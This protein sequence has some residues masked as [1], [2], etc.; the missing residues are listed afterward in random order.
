MPAPLKLTPERPHKPA[1]RRQ[2]EVVHFE[3]IDRRSGSIIL[4]DP[5]RKEVLR[6]NF[7]NA[8]PCKW[9]GPG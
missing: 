2:V 1:L 5:S 4:L 6:W 9:E 3:G 7:Y 8:W